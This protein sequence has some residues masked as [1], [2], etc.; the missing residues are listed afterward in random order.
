MWVFP[1][2]SS[3]GGGGGGPN[4]SGP[5]FHLCWVLVNINLIKPKISMKTNVK[6]SKNTWFYKIT[7]FLWKMGEGGEVARILN[8]A[9]TYKLGF[10]YQI[11]KVC[12]FQINTMWRFIF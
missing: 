3:W 8:I 1:I 5:Y 11:G 7:L 10:S 6:I 4:S 12:L 9:S 2:S